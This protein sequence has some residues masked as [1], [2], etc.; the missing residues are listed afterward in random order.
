ML[1]CDEANKDK[2]YCDDSATNREKQHQTEIAN[3]EVINQARKAEAKIQPSQTPMQV[4]KGPIPPEPETLQGQELKPVQPGGAVITPLTPVEKVTVPV[5]KK[6]E[7]LAKKK[8]VSKKTTK[9][10]PVKKSVKKKPVKKAVKKTVQKPVEKPK[11]TGGAGGNQGVAPNTEGPVVDKP[12][13]PKTT[14]DMLGIDKI[15]P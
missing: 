9:K 15:S 12:L 11:E 13:L 8:P 4:S 3:Q 1:D 5:V 14:D 6:P 2:S 7:A 10:K